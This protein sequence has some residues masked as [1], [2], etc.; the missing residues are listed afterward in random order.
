[1]SIYDYSK[2]FRDGIS[3]N[4]N[5]P[6]TLSIMGYTFEKIVELIIKDEEGK[7][8]SGEQWD[9][10]DIALMKVRQNKFNQEHKE[11]NKMATILITRKEAIAKCHGIAYP[12]A[13]V[14]ALEALGLIKIEPEELPAIEL[15][16]ANSDSSIKIWA[17][18]RTEG[19]VGKVLIN[20]IPQLK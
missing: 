3:I 10:E 2:G 14:Q 15:Y 6:Q 18:G 12:E 16:D 11:M 13:F 1:V 20:R 9:N 7:F 5:Y 8:Y 4:H 19:L 17:N